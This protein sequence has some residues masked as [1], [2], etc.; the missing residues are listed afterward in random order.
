MRNHL[1]SFFRDH[2]GSASVEFALWLPLLFGIVLMVT[3]VTLLLQKKSHY[4]DISHET[5]RIVARHAFDA[6]DGIRHASTR[7]SQDGYTPEVGVH[8]NAQ[9]Q[10]VTVVVIAESARLTPFGMLSM[11]LSDKIEVRV[12]QALEPI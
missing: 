7:L 2:S 5:A 3:D 12:S 10:I 9:N 8:I 1:N 4:W 6:E 11:M